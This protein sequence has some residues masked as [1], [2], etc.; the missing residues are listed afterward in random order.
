MLAKRKP[1]EIDVLSHVLVP[2][3]KI[4]KDSDKEKVLSKYGITDRQLPK[5]FV[6]DP[7]A[8]SLGA[9]V[10][11]VITIQRKDLTATYSSYRLI[12]S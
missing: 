10:G 1:V 6:D 8:R 5:M 11:D 2:E 4:L 3:M 7:A 9:K 12:V